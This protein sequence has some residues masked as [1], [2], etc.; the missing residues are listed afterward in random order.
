MTQ[1]LSTKTG[2]VHKAFFDDAD[3][4]AYPTGLSGVV[5]ADYVKGVNITGGTGALDGAMGN[6]S[7]FGAIDLNK[8]E[9]T[10][11]YAGTVCFSEVEER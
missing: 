8:G 10:L 5:L 2:H 1:C 11:R 9:L 6:V 3:L 4:T 7:V